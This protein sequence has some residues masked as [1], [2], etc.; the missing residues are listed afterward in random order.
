MTTLSTDSKKAP[1]QFA[2]KA[3]LSK[4]S[5]REIIAGYLAISPWIIGFI[6]FT[7]FPLLASF[8]LSF[9]KYNLVRPPQWTGFA[10]Y[11][12]MFQD[13]RFIASLVVTSTYVIVAVPLHLVTAFL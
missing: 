2:I 4:S 7:V 9:T 10:N 8:Y 6:G 11:V 5:T 13:E 12:S 3:Y 1:G